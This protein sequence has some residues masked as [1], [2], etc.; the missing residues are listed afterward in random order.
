M[1]RKNTKEE[2]S[3]SRSKQKNREEEFYIGCAMNKKEPNK[4]RT[5]SE[6]TN[7][8]KQMREK[9]NVNKEH[10]DKNRTQEI[11]RN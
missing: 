8:Q 2:V 3:N 5:T 10:L 1:C 7:E 6:T 4:S 9:K 11:N